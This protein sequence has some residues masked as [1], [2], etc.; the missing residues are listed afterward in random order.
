M[1]AGVPVIAA[2]AGGPVE[3]ISDNSNGLLFEPNDSNDLASKILFLYEN[4]EKSDGMVK[5]ALERVRA[6]D[7]NKITSELQNI[8]DEVIAEN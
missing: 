3:I 4:P 5:K 1:A 7:Q 2:R 6:F 8:Y